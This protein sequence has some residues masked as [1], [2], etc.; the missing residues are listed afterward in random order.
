MQPLGT[1]KSHNLW[2]KKIQSS[3]WD[4]NKSRNLSGQKNQATCQAKI[5]LNLSGQKK[6]RNLKGQ[7]NHAT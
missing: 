6:S 3:S 1:K 7:K 2:D 4:K 5:L